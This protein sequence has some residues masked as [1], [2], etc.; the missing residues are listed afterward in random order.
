MTYAVNATIA[1]P[2]PGNMFLRN[3]GIS[4]LCDTSFHL[5]RRL[6]GTLLGWRRWVIYAMLR[7]PPTGLDIVVQA[8]VS[9]AF[10]NAALS[11]SHTQWTHAVYEPGRL[12]M[13]KM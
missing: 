5:G 8:S 1:V 3:S 11:Q 7:A 13:V 9:Y 2:R 10:S 6:T 12:E 4:F